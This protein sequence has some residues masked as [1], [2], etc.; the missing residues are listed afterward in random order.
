MCVNHSVNLHVNRNVRYV[1]TREERQAVDHKIEMVLEYLRKLKVFLE[2]SP[3]CRFLPIHLCSIDEC[4]QYHY[5]Y[6]E[7][8]AELFPIVR[9]CYEDSLEKIEQIQQ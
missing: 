1:F 5:I 2:E 4:C 8:K 6:C 9:K 7:I 3:Q